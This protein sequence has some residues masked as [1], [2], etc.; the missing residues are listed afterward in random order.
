MATFVEEIRSLVMD[1]VDAYSVR[2]PTVDMKFDDLKPH[3]SIKAFIN[4]SKDKNRAADL[5]TKLML[6]IQEKCDDS[7]RTSFSSSD[8]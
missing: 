7:T 1:T 3:I 4:G 2:T 5:R 8:E 6:E